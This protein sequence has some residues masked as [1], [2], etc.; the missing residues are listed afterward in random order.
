MTPF[1]ALYGRPPPSIPDYQVGASSVN[2][3]DQTL[4]SRNA[5]LQQLKI[6]LHAVVN[7]MKQVADSKRKD[8]EFQVG[9]WS[10]LNSILIASKL[11]IEGHTKSWPVAFMAHTKLKKRLER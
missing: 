2:E 3:V 4:V 6:N 10:S 8:M 5:I 11:S 9:I 1:Q 7:R